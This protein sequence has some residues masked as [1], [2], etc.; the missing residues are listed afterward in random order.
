M[1][2]RVWGMLIILDRALGRA[3]PPRDDATKPAAIDLRQGQF[4]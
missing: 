2:V 3:E 1:P 4:P